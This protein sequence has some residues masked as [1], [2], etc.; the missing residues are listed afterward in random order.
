MW[1]RFRRRFV[2]TTA[3]PNYVVVM[4]LL[5]LLDLTYLHFIYISRSNRSACTWKQW[6]TICGWVDYQRW[7]LIILGVLAPLWRPREHTHFHPY[8][9]R[10]SRTPNC[11][12]SLYYP[13]GLWGC[14]CEYVKYICAVR[15]ELKRNILLECYSGL[16]ITV[17]SMSIN[18]NLSLSRP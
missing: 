7:L 18:A 2:E 8:L 14:V 3:L 4:R 9:L 12:L 11:G 17:A 6:V 16:E 1:T 15:Q 13:F 5:L 10:S